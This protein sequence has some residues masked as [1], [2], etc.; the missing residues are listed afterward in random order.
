DGANAISS[1]TNAVS[2]FPTGK[3]TVPSNLESDPIVSDITTKKAKISWGTDRGSDSKI[4]LGTKSGE[5][6]QEEFSNSNMVTNHVINLSNLSPSTTYYYIAKW[7]DEDGNT[8]Q[9]VEKNFTTEQAPIVKG[10]IVRSVGLNDVYLQFTVKGASKVKI[11]YG[12]STSFGGALEIATS[13]SETT[14]TSI[15]SS[16][17]DGTKY[18]YKVNSFDLEGSEY[19]G[20]ILDFKTLPK[21]SVSGIKIQQI[22][23]TADT[24]IVVS[25]NSNTDISSILSYYPEDNPKD[26]KNSVDLTLINGAHKLA[27]SSLLPDKLYVLTVR[28]RDRI[29]NEAVSENIRFTTATDTRPPVITDTVVESFPVDTSSNSSKKAQVVISWNTDELST[30]SVEY[31][32]GYSD[33][34]QLKSTTD[35]TLSYNHAVVISGLE[36][37]KVY[38]FRAISKDK[39]ENAAYSPNMVSITLKSSQDATELILGSLRNLFNF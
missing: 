11:Y 17:E 26:V 13:E 38:H 27:L 37:S 28:G 34:Y 9:S 10:V 4:A 3:W 5:Y 6:N 33:T 36:P 12:K 32:E 7:T 22:K 29:G 30:S 35:F 2:I 25:W 31:G 23:N 39:A 1:G 16:L 20:T 19:D 14:Y 24:T 21:P 18:Y 8:G 15:I